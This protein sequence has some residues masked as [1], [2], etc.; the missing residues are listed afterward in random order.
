MFVPGYTNFIPRSM[1]SFLGF[2]S[3]W[4]HTPECHTQALLICK[5]G[6]TTYIPSWMQKY[7]IKDVITYIMVERCNYLWPEFMIDLFCLVPLQLFG[8][9]KI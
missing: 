4:E 9:P 7:L 2:C 6:S 3:I 5:K 1:W 8:I